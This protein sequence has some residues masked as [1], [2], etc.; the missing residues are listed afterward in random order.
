L[1]SHYR[2]PDTGGSSRSTAESIASA[3]P[4]DPAALVTRAVGNL[5]KMRV[6]SRSGFGTTIGMSTSKEGRGHR[7][8]FLRSGKDE[9]SEVAFRSLAAR[10]ECDT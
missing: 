8:L 3:H 2:R 9:V 5:R 6:A 7:K 10:D 4:S 1:R